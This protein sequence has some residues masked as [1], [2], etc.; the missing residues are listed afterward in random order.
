MKM[1]S[2]K[3]R[4]N[5]IAEDG[6]GE[7][8]NRRSSIRNNSQWQLVQGMIL[9]VGVEIKD[10]DIQAV[11][12]GMKAAYHMGQVSEAEAIWSGGII[13]NDMKQKNYKC[14]NESYQFQMKDSKWS[15]QELTEN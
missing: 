9:H 13:Q 3:G 10:N 6:K 7:F 5:E 1:K 8:Q 14:S 4:K 2:S 11:I 12:W 15:K